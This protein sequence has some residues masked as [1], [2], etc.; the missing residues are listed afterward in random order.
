MNRG[1]LV[2]VGLV[3]SIAIATVGCG[4]D[5]GSGGSGGGDGGSDTGAG[6]SGAAGAGDVGGGGSGAGDEGGGGNAPAAATC[7]SYCATIDDGCLDGNKQYL[8]EA[9]CVAECAAF[10]QGE[11]GDV[12][13]DSLEC[14]AYHAG[15]AAGGT[16]PNIHC[17]HGGPLGSGP[18]AMAGCTGNTTADR[19]AAFCAVGFEICG[20]EDNYPYDNEDDCITECSGLFSNNS[21]DDVDFNTGRVSGATLACRMY[22]L[23]AAVQDK[24]THCGHIGTASPCVP[25]N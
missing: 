23:S 10:E 14:R 25:A 21:T 7:A 22:H 18:T 13:G 20:A 6:G 16:D 24:A 2:L 1:M 15:V 17:V 5:T 19:C 4:D 12:S 8:S 3:S 11:I 9:D